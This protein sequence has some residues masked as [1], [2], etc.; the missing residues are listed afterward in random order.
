MWEGWTKNI[1]IG[2]QDRLWLLLIG[3][4]TGLAG[5]LVLPIWLLGGIGWWA[6]EPGLARAIVPLEALLVWAYLLVWRG[7]A[8]RAF[9]I[10]PLYGFT[11]P[12]GAL[13]FTGMML[14][15]GYNV[16]SGRGVTWRGRK[17]KK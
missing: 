14:A 11:L 13:V 3:A 9:G 1:Y 10:S 15:S 12:L 5:A 4:L 17:Y 2:L 7:R 16:V 8:S 6:V